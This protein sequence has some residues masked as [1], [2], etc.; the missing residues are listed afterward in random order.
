MKPP[1]D[2]ICVPFPQPW[3]WCRSHL[4]NVALVEGFGVCLE[5]TKSSNPE[6]RIMFDDMKHLTAQLNQSDQTKV[7]RN[8]FHTMRPCAITRETCY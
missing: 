2:S 8:L 3:E 1:S 5:K 6:C 4:F 7:C